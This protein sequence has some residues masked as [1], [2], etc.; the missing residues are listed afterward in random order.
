MDGIENGGDFILEPIPGVTSPDA[1]GAPGNVPEVQPNIPSVPGMEPALPDVAV[2]PIVPQAPE[3]VPGHIEVQHDVGDA[4]PVPVTTSPLAEAI[5]LAPE[6]QPIQVTDEATVPTAESVFEPTAETPAA[7]IAPATSMLPE[8]GAEPAP[9]AASEAIDEILTPNTDNAPAA[10]V[11]PS[12]DE[13]TPAATPESEIMPA[14]AE[15]SPAPAAEKIK[16]D[17]FFDAQ[18]GLKDRMM[19]NILERLPG[20]QEVMEQPEKD[21]E[22]SLNRLRELA[23][24][25]QHI[26]LTNDQLEISTADGGTKACPRAEMQVAD[27]TLPD[28]KSASKVVVFQVNQRLTA[29]TG[30]TFPMSD[31]LAVALPTEDR[32][33]IAIVELNDEVFTDVSANL[34]LSASIAE[35]LAGGRPIILGATSIDTLG[36]AQQVTRLQQIR[37]MSEAFITA[38]NENHIE[39]EDLMQQPL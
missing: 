17:G 37:A 27:V 32:P 23:K 3:A 20:A 15:A 8:P 6:P 34:V 2:T 21:A 13:S 38:F 35:P 31:Y 33:N 7:E 28:E 25:G 19:L 16:S 26:T 1:P 24:E 4:Q 12:S 11:A 9:D 18:M 22:A 36:R 30:D 29:E 5:P 14:E 39:S 10:E